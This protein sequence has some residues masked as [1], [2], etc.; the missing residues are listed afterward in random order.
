MGSRCGPREVDRSVRGLAPFTVRF[1]RSTVSTVNNAG[2]TTRVPSARCTT[3]NASVTSLAIDCLEGQVRDLDFIH[4]HPRDHAGD[5]DF[6][7]V[8]VLDL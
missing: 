5:V 2:V 6:D 1:T 3:L 7:Q 8:V 4:A